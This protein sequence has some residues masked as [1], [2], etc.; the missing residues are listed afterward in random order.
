[1]TRSNIVNKGWVIAWMAIIPFFFSCRSMQ[2][3]QDYQGQAFSKEHLIA[4]LP[5][6]LMETSGLEY[7]FGRLWSFNDSGGEAE[8][9]SFRPSDPAGTI[10][11]YPVTGAENV[12]WEDIA[13]NKGYFYISDAGN[14]TGSRDTLNIYKVIVDTAD[15][16]ADVLSVIS[17]SYPGKTPGFSN[18]RKNPFDSEGLTVKDDSLWLFTKN[19]QDESSCI[20]TYPLEGGYYFRKPGICLQTR[21]LVTG[22]DFDRSTGMLW[23]IGYHH[24]IPA[25]RV[26]AVTANAAPRPVAVFR[27]GNRIGLQT[28]AIVCAGDGYIYFSYEKSKRRQGLFR[29]KNPF[30]GEAVQNSF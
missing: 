22:A 29:M 8:L 27:L 18:C 2:Y 6:S 30:V 15:A 11:A 12:D 10:I 4:R 20:Y 17:F 1:M 28:E 21:M 24:F 23:L 16:T 5:V 13:F 9:F 19:W 25:I 14:N 3:L 7:H 26:Y